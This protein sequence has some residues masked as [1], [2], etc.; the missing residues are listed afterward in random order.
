MLIY[1]LVEIEKISIHAPVRGATKYN[2]KTFIDINI[3][4]HA[5]VRGATRIYFGQQR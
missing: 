2:I 4:I 3:S 5:P 1:L